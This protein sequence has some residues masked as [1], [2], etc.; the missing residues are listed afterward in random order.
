MTSH[1]RL[2]A[3]ALATFTAVAPAGA[4]MATHN[5]PIRIDQCFITSKKLSKNASG[6]QIDYTNVGQRTYHQITFAVGYR[7]SA[8]NYVR[9][10]IDDGTFAPGAQVQHHFPLYSDITYAGKQTHGCKAIAAS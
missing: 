4:Q 1:L 5:P 7:N 6:T 2:V 8:G 10:V 9:K 3:V